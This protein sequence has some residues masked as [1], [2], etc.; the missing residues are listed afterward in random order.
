M[1]TG[2]AATKPLVG[3]SR[4]VT[5]GPPGVPPNVCTSKTE[6]CVNPKYTGR[7]VMLNSRTFVLLPT[8]AI[9]RDQ[10]SVMVSTLLAI[11][12]VGGVVLLLAAVK[13][14]TWTA[15]DWPM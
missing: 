1:P 8:V 12:G 11:A 15:T 3:K 6:A 10:R 14:F 13:A 9:K 2:A 7:A 4:L 5:P